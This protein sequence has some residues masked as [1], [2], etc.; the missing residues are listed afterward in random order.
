MAVVPFPAGHGQ[1]LLSL[2]QATC[3]YA[4]QAIQSDLDLEI[5]AGQILSLLGP[6][7]VGKT[8]LFKTLLGFLPLLAGQL[9]I[10]GRALTDWQRPALAQVIGYVPQA[11]NPPFPYRVRQVVVMGRTAHLGLFGAPSRRDHALADAALAELGITALADR[12]YTQLSGGEQQLVLIARALVQQPRLLLLDEPTASLDFGNQVR[13]LEQILALARRGI[14]IVMTTHAPDHAL[15]CHHHVAGARV[16]LLRRHQA[17]LLGPAPEVLTAAQLGQ[18]YGVSVRIGA[19]S[20]ASGEDPISVC[21]PQLRVRNANPGPSA[22][23]HPHNDLT[24][25]RGSFHQSRTP[26]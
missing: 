13:V 26:S 8:T 24:T 17:A 15:W 21:V 14:A 11:H 16:A 4:G 9:L 3:G 22:L 20:G 7:G 19:L 2:R 23:L 25:P 5:H 18:A 10:A 12:I 6:N 1:P